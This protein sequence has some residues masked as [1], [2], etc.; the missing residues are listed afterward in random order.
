MNKLVI[1]HTKGERIIGKGQRVFIVAEM[2]GNHNG[3]IQRAYQIIDAAAAA[4]ADAVK[5]QTYTSDTITIDSDREYFQVKESKLW[6]GQTLYKLYGQ[7]YTPWEWQQELKAYAESKNLIF[8]S[9]P[10]DD[11]AVDF[12]EKLQVPLYKVSSFE[13]V[14]TPLLARIGQTNRPVIMSR[15][16]ASAEELEEALR[17]LKETGCPA[18]ALLHCI[19]AYPAKSEEMNLLTIPDMAERF[20]VVTGLSDHSLGQ[21]GRAHV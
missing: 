2:S 8:F 14:D 12:L 11:T 3:D 4:G 15:G 21:I 20:E 13:V 16:M 1:K 19:S 10:F 7:A 17:V 9:T 18:V 6:G 5:L